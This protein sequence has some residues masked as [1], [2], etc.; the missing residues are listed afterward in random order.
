MG[1]ESRLEKD[2]MGD[3]REDMTVADLAKLMMKHFVVQKQELSDMRAFYQGQVD[4]LTNRVDKLDRKPFD[5][6]RT[7]CITDL[8]PNRDAPDDVH[9]GNI[10]EAV[11]LGCEIVNT[12]RMR[13]YG[14]RPG[15]L[16]CELGS[17]QDKINVLQCKMAIREQVPGV[18]IRSSKTYAERV[19]DDN[20]STILSLLPDGYK[21]KTAS[22]G[23][24][25]PKAEYMAE[26]EEEQ[27]MDSNNNTSMSAPAPA[28]IQSD[29]NAAA[30]NTQTPTLNMQGQQ[31]QGQGGERGSF[32]PGS[33]AR[34]GYRGDRSRPS[35]RRSFRPFRQFR[36]GDRGGYR[37]D[38]RGY[39]RGGQ[40][41][42]GRGSPAWGRGGRGSHQAWNMGPDVR[43]KDIRSNLSDAEFPRLPTNNAA[44]PL[45]G[46]S[47][48]DKKRP[49]EFSPEVI[50]TVTSGVADASSSANPA[51]VNGKNM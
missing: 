31:Q 23:R 37:G 2:M 44:T 46:Q 5:P 47:E 48:P 16:K 14:K 4:D 32:R 3:I 9:L 26:F 51:Q 15:L 13:A 20:F 11:G 19:L 22:D 12:R 30:Q 42:W 27:Q 1:E 43:Q 24:I 49:R 35:F 10:F 33:W 6:E 29:E 45:K 40:G 38:S 28:S 36:S 7:I 41:A 25:I 50:E 18:W 34:G 39:S 8:P 21:F 17:E